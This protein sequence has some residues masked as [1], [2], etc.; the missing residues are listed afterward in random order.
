[1]TAL[2]DCLLNDEQMRSFISKGYIKL[3]LPL[4]ADFHAQVYADTEKV[5][6]ESGHPGDAIYEAVPLLKRSPI[7]R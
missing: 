5:F 1:M 3:H 6:A 2:Q 7:P 4:E